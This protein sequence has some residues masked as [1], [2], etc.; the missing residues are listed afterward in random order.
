MRYAPSNC[1]IKKNLL[2]WWKSSEAGMSQIQ[3][4]RDYVYE[5]RELRR[6]DGGFFNCGVR[7]PATPF[8]RLLDQIPWAG[9]KLGEKY[10]DYYCLS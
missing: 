5:V 2:A 8:E 4:K 6:Q 7:E 1:R 10:R 3:A 9:A